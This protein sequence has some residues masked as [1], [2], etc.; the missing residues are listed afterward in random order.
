MTQDLSVEESKTA[1]VAVAKTAQ[2][3]VA[4]NSTD[5]DQ[6]GKQ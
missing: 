6:D 1:Q 4:K 5:S 3:V 2:V